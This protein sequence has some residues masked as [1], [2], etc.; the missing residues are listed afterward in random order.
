MR[1]RH[2]H[3]WKNTTCYSGYL[4]ENTIEHQQIINKNLNIYLFVSMKNKNCNKTTIKI[5]MMKKTRVQSLQKTVEPLSQVSC[6]NSRVLSL[7]QLQA[8]QIQNTISQSI[9]TKKKTKLRFKKK[10]QNKAEKNKQNNNAQ[11]C[12]N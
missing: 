6:G 3:V 11:G 4:R 9:I 1:S 2:V 8:H 7:I 5:T 10:Q 12:L